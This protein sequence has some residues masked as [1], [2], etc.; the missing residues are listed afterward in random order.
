MAFHVT[1]TSERKG[2]FADADLQFGLK[3]DQIMKNVKYM[4]YWINFLIQDIEDLT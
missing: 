4:C 1:P 2:H 3:R